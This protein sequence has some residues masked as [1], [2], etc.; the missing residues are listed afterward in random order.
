MKMRHS[1]LRPSCRIFMLFM[2]TPPS[3]A[4]SPLVIV[5]LANL[6]GSRISYGGALLSVFLLDPQIMQAPCLEELG[7]KASRRKGG[8]HA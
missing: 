8:E 2:F 4:S 7:G 1:P 3:L 5:E 6:L